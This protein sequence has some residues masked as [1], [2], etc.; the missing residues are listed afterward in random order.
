MRHN[1]GLN[2]GELIKR[3]EEL[4][5]GT[6]VRFDFADLVPSRDFRSYRGYYE[7]IALGYSGARYGS[8]TAAE[9]LAYYNS[10]IGEKY[11]GYKGG[12]YVATEKTGVWVA[13]S[14]RDCTGTVIRNV[15]DL[16]YG[17]A[18]IETQ[19]ED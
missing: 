4:D 17:Y 6:K 16:G 10:L 5:E 15:R 11:Y 18:I 1:N 13:N 12:E 3:L 9:L 8:I 19:Y 2:L 7:D 14:Y